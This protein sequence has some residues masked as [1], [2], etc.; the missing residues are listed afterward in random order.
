MNEIEVELRV[1]K[2]ETKLDALREAQ[3]VVNAVQGNLNQRIEDL[4]V[5][6]A[7][8]EAKPSSHRILDG[9]ATLPKPAPQLSLSSDPDM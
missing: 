4:A 3:A 9:S 6:V 8:M 7:V 5:K 1:L 2:A